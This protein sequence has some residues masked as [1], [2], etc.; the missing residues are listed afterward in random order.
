M[1]TAAL[2]ITIFTTRRNLRDLNILCGGLAQ[3]LHNHSRESRSQSL[4][5]I[6]MHRGWDSVSVPAPYVCNVCVHG[7]RAYA[8]LEL[9][10][11][12]ARGAGIEANTRSRDNVIFTFDSRHNT[13]AVDRV[14][15]IEVLSNYTSTRHISRLPDGEIMRLNQGPLYANFCTAVSTLLLRRIIG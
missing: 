5:C 7:T 1:T 10:R 8:G 13:G 6:I 11:K 4:G 12:N 9:V 3:A 14:A 2:S 15:R